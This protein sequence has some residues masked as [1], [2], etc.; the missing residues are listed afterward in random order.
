M[1]N[2]AKCVLCGDILESFHAHDYVSC[3][4]G[5]ISIDGG[6]DQYRCS[7]RNFENFLRIDD[8]DNEIVVTLAQGNEIPVKEIEKKEEIAF[9]TRKELLD[10]LENMYKTIE[11]LPDAAKYAPVNHYDL[12][13]LIALVHQILKS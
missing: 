1:R 5:E 10:M 8:E 13:C 4:C 11:N 7:A 6:N 12:Y 2:R 3:R 9:P